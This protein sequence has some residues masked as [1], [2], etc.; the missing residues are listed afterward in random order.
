MGFVI[1]KARE[2]PGDYGPLRHI[3]GAGIER[4][5]GIPAIAA[6]RAADHRG[7]RE[8]P[9]ASRSTIPRMIRLMEVMLHG[10]TTLGGW[11]AKQI[12]GAILTAFHLC[13]DS[14]GLNQLRYDLRKMKAHGLI[15]RDDQHYAYRLTDKGTEVALT[16]VL[17]HQRLC[18]PLANSLFHHQPDHAAQPKSKL[19]TAYHKAD[20]SITKVLELLEAA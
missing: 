13:A 5:L 4:S 20:A 12:H 2:V 17:F 7:N 11:T 16:F 10:G 14:Y 1:T 3:P 18:G 8:I 15:V 19:E 9:K 6:C